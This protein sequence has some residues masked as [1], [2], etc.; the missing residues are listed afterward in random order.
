MKYLKEVVRMH[1][2]PTKACINVE[3]ISSN[4]YWKRLK[5]R[6]GVEN[7][8]YRSQV[9]WRNP[10]IWQ[11]E[12]QL[13]CRLGTSVW[14]VNRIDDILNQPISFGHFKLKLIAIETFVLQNV[15]SIY[16]VYY[17]QLYNENIYIYQ[18]KTPTYFMTFIIHLLKNS[19]R[20]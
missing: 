14:Y 15:A 2:G 1:I 18:R 8:Q 20:S 4:S 11:I 3:G 17:A 7:E 5:T 19:R 10:S 13:S 6:L 12:R 9:T 16:Q